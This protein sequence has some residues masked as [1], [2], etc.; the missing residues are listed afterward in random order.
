M[1]PHRIEVLKD[2]TQ[3]SQPQHLK[4]YND[5]LPQGWSNSIKAGWLSSLSTHTGRARAELYWS[6]VTFPIPNYFRP[7]PH[8]H[9]IMTCFED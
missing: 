9:K 7:F 4:I 1:R 5:N 8:H 3:N 6:C 2:Y